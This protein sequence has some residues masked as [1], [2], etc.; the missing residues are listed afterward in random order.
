MR[1]IAFIA[2]LVYSIR[3]INHPFQY[4]IYY[5]SDA[6]LIQYG[7]IWYYNV[8]HLNQCEGLK[9][10]PLEIVRKSTIIPPLMLDR[11]ADGILKIIFADWTAEKAIAL[12]EGSNEP[13]PA[14]EENA[15]AG[16]VS[17]TI[18]QIL[19]QCSDEDAA[20]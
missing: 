16:D 2:D 9:A 11:Y 19:S 6:S 5:C 4:N 7:K 10:P 18:R 14:S 3:T 15:P 8:F 17:E 1:C 12:C 13:E 20:S